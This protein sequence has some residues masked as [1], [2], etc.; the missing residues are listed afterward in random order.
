M[1]PNRFF[2][3]MIL[4]PAAAGLL[5]ATAACSGTGAPVTITSTTTATG[6]TVKTLSYA[7]LVT[8]VSGGYSLL[9]A[10]AAALVA[11]GKLDATKVATAEHDVDTALAVVTAGGTSFAL[12]PQ[13]VA[14]ALLTSLLVLAAL[15]PVAT[16]P[17]AVGLAIQ[18][19]ESTLAAFI[20]LEPTIAATI[21]ANHAVTV[22]AVVP[23][24]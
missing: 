23:A 9:K 20:A 12:T 13:S 2:H 19:G 1:N 18:V 15:V 7:Q 21:A 16:L 24:T 22:T 8:D 17:A 6:T 5:F 11:A 10:E 3:R 4:A 14:Q